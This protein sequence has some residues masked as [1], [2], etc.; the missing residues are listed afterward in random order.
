MN[1]FNILHFLGLNTS[2]TQKALQKSLW[3]MAMRFLLHGGTVLGFTILISYFLSYYGGTQL[4]ILFVYISI[5]TLLGTVFT[6]SLTE[7][8]KVS[9]ILKYA[10]VSLSLLIFASFVGLQYVNNNFTHLT[11]SVGILFSI[12]VTQLNILFSMYIEQSFSPLESEEAFPIIESGEPLG[13][14]LSGVIAFSLPYF[15]YPSSLLLGWSVIFFLFF[16]ILHLREFI[17]NENTEEYI[18]K[19]PT[20]K[21]S[22]KKSCLQNYYTILQENSLVK[23]LF[24]FVLLQSAGYILIEMIYA[25]SASVLFEESHAEKSQLVQELA[26]GIGTFHAWTYGILFFLQITLASKIQH[27]LGIIKSIFIQPFIQIFATFLTLISGSFF[28]GLLGKGIYEV[29]GGVSRNSYHSSFYVFSPELRDGIKEFLDGIARPIGMITVSLITMIASVVLFKTGFGFS[30][31]YIFCSV[32]L[33][34]V[35]GGTLYIYYNIKN[36]YSKSK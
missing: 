34:I 30:Q 6:H 32:L 26:H 2:L 9:S 11:A 10:S 1:T 4:P 3:L 15:F 16:I 33:I 29:I 22:S 35:L 28:I 36:Q 20:H 25:M 31:F 14:L 24:F 23:S 7:K 18:Y 5:G 27:F 13:G 12:G 19:K 8:F 17:H 21:C